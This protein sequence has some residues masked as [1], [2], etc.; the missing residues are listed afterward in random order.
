MRAFLHAGRDGR[1]HAARQV[2]TPP[3]WT[4]VGMTPPPRPAVSTTGLFEYGER[5]RSPQAFV[6]AG[7]PSC[8]RHISAIKSLTSTTQRTRAA[9]GRRPRKPKTANYYTFDS[10]YNL[11]PICAG[12]G[13]PRTSCVAPKALALPLYLG[14][15]RINGGGGDPAR[16]STEEAAPGADPARTVPRRSFC[17]SISTWPTDPGDSARCCATSSPSGPGP[18]ARTILGVVAR[19][20]QARFRRR[21]VHHPV[22]AGVAR[23]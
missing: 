22:W 17:W 16:I 13:V 19:R 14:R 12:V 2:A 18:S 9:F 7:S 4:R 1:A 6:L 15:R 10:F 5:D 20:H 11:P 3:A 8:S 23:R 21:I